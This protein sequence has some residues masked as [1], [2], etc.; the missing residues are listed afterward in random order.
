MRSHKKTKKIKFDTHVD[1]DNYDCPHCHHFV[2]AD[3]SMKTG[4]YTCNRCGQ[5]S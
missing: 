1:I 5:V 4:K 3:L 2:S